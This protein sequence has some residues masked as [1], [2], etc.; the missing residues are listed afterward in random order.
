MIARDASRVPNAPG[1]RAGGRLRFSDDRG[2][3]SGKTAAPR[4]K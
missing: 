4:P 3:W 1:G 2:G